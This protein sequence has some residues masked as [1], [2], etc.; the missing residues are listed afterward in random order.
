[1]GEFNGTCAW[2]LLKTIKRQ[3]YGIGRIFV[4]TA[5]LSR[6]MPE[7][8]DLFKSNMNPKK[9]PQDWLYFK[10]EKGFKIA[11]DGSRVILCGVNK[12]KKEIKDEKC[13]NYLRNHN[14]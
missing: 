2:E 1:M 3:D 8:V 6:I 11:P 4:N 14:G 5:G 12:N 10:G 7:G 9:M 13:I